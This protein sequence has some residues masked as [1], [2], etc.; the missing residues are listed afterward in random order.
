MFEKFVLKIDDGSSSFIF[1]GFKIVT[2]N[3]H[4]SHGIFE[5]WSK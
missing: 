2:L 1:N 4:M 5:F 3:T